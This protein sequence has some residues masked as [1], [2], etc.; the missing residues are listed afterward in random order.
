MGA[1]DADQV[2]ES[3]YAADEDFDERL[4]RVFGPAQ[5]L[6]E[7]MYTA[8]LLFVNFGRCLQ[9]SRA[10]GHIVFVFTEQVQIL[11]LVLFL[12]GKS[13]DAHS[14]QT[15]QIAQGFRC[16]ACVVRLSTRFTACAASLGIFLDG[17]GSWG[18]SF[19]SGL[20]GLACCI[21]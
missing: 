10:Y 9:A 3:L 14:G 16:P 20:L 12:N 17:G 6:V 21:C 13:S 15:Q 5:A 7:L 19:I 18:V 2:A 11:L 4:E 8:L 1:I